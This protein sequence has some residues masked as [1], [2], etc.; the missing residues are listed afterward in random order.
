MVETLESSKYAWYLS[1]RAFLFPKIHKLR[2]LCDYAKFKKYL[3]VHFRQVYKFI[4]NSKKYA[5]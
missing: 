2:N 1:L 4:R 3:K 5:E